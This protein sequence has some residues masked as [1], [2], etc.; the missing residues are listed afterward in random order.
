MYFIQPGYNVHGIYMQNWNEHE[1]TGWC[2]GEQDYLD[3][4]K[5]ADIIGVPIKKVSYEKEYWNHVFRLPYILDILSIYLG[6]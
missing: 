3:A 1:E 4:C 5:A 2:T 6:V